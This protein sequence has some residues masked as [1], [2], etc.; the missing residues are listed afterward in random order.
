VNR[1]HYEGRFAGAGAPHFPFPSGFD[2]ANR[3]LDHDACDGDPLEQLIATPM[4]RGLACESW[5]A[6]TGIVRTGAAMASM[7]GLLSWAAWE[8]L[9][10]R[11]RWDEPPGVPPSLP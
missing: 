10:G 5:D 4:D 2:L 11:R 6:D 9:T 7:A 1:Y 3:L 8:H